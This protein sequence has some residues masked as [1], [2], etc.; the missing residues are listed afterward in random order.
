[1]NN[2]KKATRHIL[3]ALYPECENW[4]DIINK[5]CDNQP[6]G[7]CVVCGAIGSLFEN[8]T[9]ISLAMVQTAFYTRDS[10]SLNIHLPNLKIAP[11]YDNNKCKLHY[12]ETVII[13]TL[14]KNA[15]SLNL[16]QQNE[17]VWQSIVDIFES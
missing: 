17:K 16:D 3:T 1:M 12:G 9:P 15:Q 2:L 6:V 7:K 4:E 11:A 10:N 13:W 8:G 14:T 5:H